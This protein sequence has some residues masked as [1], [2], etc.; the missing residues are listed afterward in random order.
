MS[1][2]I[3]NDVQ[4]LTNGNVL[5]TIK[6]AQNYN[7]FNESNVSEQSGYF[8][9]FELDKK[10]EGQSITVKRISGNPQGQEK[11]AEDIQW[12]L[13]LT[14]GKDTVYEIK[15]DGELIMTLNFQNATFMSEPISD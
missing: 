13:R 9:P 2:L 6:Y 7:E 8:F 12:V 1:D 4:V 11:T 5:G 15:A 14:D 3:G 10:Y